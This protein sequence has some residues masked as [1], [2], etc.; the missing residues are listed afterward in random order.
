MIVVRSSTQRKAPA[1]LSVGG[2]WIGQVSPFGPQSTPHCYT[3]PQQD[4]LPMR[5]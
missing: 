5:E 4:R 1:G 2:A 3:S